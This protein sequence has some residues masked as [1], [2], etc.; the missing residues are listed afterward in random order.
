MTRWDPAFENAGKTPGTEIWRIEVSLNYSDYIF[1]QII[2]AMCVLPLLLLLLENEG[3][4]RREEHLW[5]VLFWR[6]VHFVECRFLIMSDSCISLVRNGI[7]LP[8]GNI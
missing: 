7:R 4:S 3:S 2:T 5:K 1:P 8:T 6:F